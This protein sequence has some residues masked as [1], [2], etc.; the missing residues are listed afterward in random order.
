MADLERCAASSQ[1]GAPDGLQISLL[2]AVDGAY[3]PSVYLVLLIHLK[4]SIACDKNGDPV[5]GSPALS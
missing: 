1:R 3:F 2:E 5:C 4:L